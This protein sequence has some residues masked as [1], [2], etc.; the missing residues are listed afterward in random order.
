MWK[1]ILLYVD[2]R[3]AGYCTNVP[4]TQRDYSNQLSFS[5]LVTL[6][7]VIGKMASEQQS[8]L[9]VFL[10]IVVTPCGDGLALRGGIGITINLPGHSM[11]VTQHIAQESKEVWRA[12]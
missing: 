1:W 4:T 6:S 10:P 11:S 7:F 2:K 3:A 5:V 8:G 12:R 9:S